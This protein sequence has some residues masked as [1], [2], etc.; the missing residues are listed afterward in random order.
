[1]N[2]LLVDKPLKEKLK[3]VIPLK[4]NRLSLYTKDMCSWFAC[5]SGKGKV[6]KYSDMKNVT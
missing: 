6:S 3:G 2:E 4:T 1:M 5:N